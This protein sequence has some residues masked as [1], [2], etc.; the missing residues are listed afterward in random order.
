MR[1]E[2]CAAV[3]SATA[4]CAPVPFSWK[5]S[6]THRELTELMEEAGETKPP[7]PQCGKPQTLSINC[8]RPP[9]ITLS[10]SEGTG[11]KRNRPL[12]DAQGYPL[13]AL[14]NRRGLQTK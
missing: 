12:A 11:F 10:V 8:I 3:C 9:R 2:G 4:I 6:P 7:A 5:R 14:Q 13:N 1:R